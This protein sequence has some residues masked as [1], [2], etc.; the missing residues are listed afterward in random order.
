MT[1][2]LSKLATTDALTGISNRRIF[3]ENGERLFAEAKR[4]NRDF[5]I[6]IMD[7]DKFKS[8]NDIYGHPVGDKV[9][10]HTAKASIELLRETDTFA[11]IGG[12]EFG[13]LLPET[14]PVHAAKVAEKIRSEVEGLHFTTE[15]GKVIHQ[16]VSI[17]ITNYTPE[18]TDLN[19]LIEKC[20][21]ALYR[22]KNTGRNKCIH[23]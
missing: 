22:A 8:I 7:I 20:D 9:L 16:T 15:N 12:E 11:R 6:L 13:I 3:M 5:A 17:G 18:I 14:G 19:E 2:A 4:Y 21:G 10:I 23:F 1:D